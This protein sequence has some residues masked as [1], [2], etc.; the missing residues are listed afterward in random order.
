[1]KKILPGL[2]APVLLMTASCSSSGKADLL[3]VDLTDNTHTGDESSLYDVVSTIHPELTDST[4]I[5]FPGIVGADGAD[6]YVNADDN[7]MVFDMNN[8]R[9]LAS[10]CRRGTGPGEFIS[11]WYVWKTAGGDGWTVLDVRGNRVLEY[12][13]TGG[14]VASHDNDSIKFLIPCGDG[15]AGENEFQE[16]ENKKYFLYTSDW[17]SRGTIETPLKF[18]SMDGGN[19][20][21]ETDYVLSGK[22]SMILER[23]T[24]YN[25]STDGSFTPI[26]AIDCGSKKMPE[27]KSWEEMRAQSGNYISYRVLAT[28][29]Y[30]LIVSWLGDDVSTRVVSRADGS[31]VFSKTRPK[32]DGMARV[33]IE[34]REVPAIIQGY[35][36]G[37]HLYLT[38][39]SE[40]MSEITG[41]E[42]S[43][44]E[45]I[46]VRLNP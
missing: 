31:V 17:K 26:L 40:E 46:K 22:E 36:D 21:T 3:T 28:Y 2:I 11:G 35:S 29:K 45:V 18:R 10:F 41:D 9:C 39:T 33:K 32:N 44:P 37:E 16:G 24:L 23:D 34:D 43:N 38:V 15:W 12:G 4:L 8:K 25:L 6:I 7:F 19:V 13:K 27:F 5:G 20:R 1:M 30:F 14:F 42:E